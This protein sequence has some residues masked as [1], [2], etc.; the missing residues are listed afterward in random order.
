MYAHNSQIYVSLLVFPLSKPDFQIS[1]VGKVT[2]DRIIDG[3]SIKGK[4][5]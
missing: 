3:T 4:A 2:L 1:L 5:K